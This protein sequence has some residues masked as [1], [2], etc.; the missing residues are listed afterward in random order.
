MAL[1]ACVDARFELIRRHRLSGGVVAT[2]RRE[3]HGC[4]TVIRGVSNLGHPFW[5][6]TPGGRSLRLSHHFGHFSW[7]VGSYL[8]VLGG[9][10]ALGEVCLERGE[11]G[12][13]CHL[14]TQNAS[15]STRSPGSEGAVEA[16]RGQMSGWETTRLVFQPQRVVFL[17]PAASI[18]PKRLV[19]IFLCFSARFGCFLSLLQ[20]RSVVLEPS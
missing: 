11:E 9:P 7:P 3:T 4:S 5:S 14:I 6:K 16:F 18:R 17:N 20:S 10:L 19:G 12:G 15:F 13:G 8:A 1:V 2:R